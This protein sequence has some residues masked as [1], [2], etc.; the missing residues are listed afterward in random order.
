ML[1]PLQ[2]RVAALV[3]GI[4][5]ASEFALA[6]G[7]ALIVQGRISRQTRDLD[8]FGPAPAAV[9]RLLPLVEAE[10]AEE[11]LAVRRVMVNPGFARLE[12]GDGRDQTELDLAAD[13]RL[14]PVQPT[15]PAPT[16]SGQELGADKVLA[17]FSRAEARDFSDLVPLEEAYGLDQLLELASQKDLGFQP[18]YFAEMLERF[19]RFRREEFD[20]TD[21]QFA[22]LKE[23]VARWHE[24]ALERSR[25]R[26]RERGDGL[27]LG[28]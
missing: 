17:I 24:R 26:S 28:F 21:E 9:D 4:E 10:L 27:D 16:L 11:G 7:A 20:I 14:L 8:F 15:T 2:Q 19:D 18:K 25:E 22:R 6:G 13:A 23:S 3:A 1:S 5:D 12:I